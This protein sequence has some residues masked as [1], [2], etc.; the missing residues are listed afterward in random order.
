MPSEFTITPKAQ[1]QLKKVLSKTG[2]SPKKNIRFRILVEGGGC[3]GFQYVFKMDDTYNKED[4]IY[5]EEPG[6]VIIDDISLGLLKGASLDY[7]EELIGS[8]FVIKNNPQATTS[9]G[10]KTSFSVI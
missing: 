4:Q 6:E 9:C 7:E 2:D 10:C 8:Q 3:A 1:D 5:G